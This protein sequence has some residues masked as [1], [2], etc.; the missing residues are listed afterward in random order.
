MKTIEE[1]IS[2]KTKDIFLFLTTKEIEIYEKISKD[3]NFKKDLY[4]IEGFFRK[5]HMTLKEKIIFKSKFLLNY[6]NEEDFIISLN[7]FLLKIGNEAKF[8]KS[9]EQFFF[10]FHK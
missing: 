10:N 4:F 8:S 9:F 7:D 3:K 1:K 2:S 6:P 5:Q